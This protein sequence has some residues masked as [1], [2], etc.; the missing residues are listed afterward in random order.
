MRLLILSKVPIFENYQ[1]RDSVESE[2]PKVLKSFGIIMANFIIIIAL[3]NSFTLDI[4]YSLSLYF[5]AI[6]LY[7]CAYK[8]CNLLNPLYVTCLS[9]TMLSGV[10]IST[11]L[12]CF[13]YCFISLPLDFIKKHLR[14]KPL[15]HHTKFIS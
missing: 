3:F 2:K 7:Y 1:T 12:L 14:E 11:F 10:L 8:R 6:C 4:A 5:I 9:L 13:I 15:S